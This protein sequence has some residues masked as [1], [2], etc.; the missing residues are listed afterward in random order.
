MEF[1]EVERERLAK[2]ERLRASGVEPYP[3]RS[4]F[5]RRR[6]MAAD[7]V[8]RALASAQNHADALENNEAA[9][10]GR[11]VARRIMGKAAF[12][13]VED[14]SGKIQ[15]YARVGDDSLDADSF[16]RFKELDLGD[17]IE[18]QGTLFVTKTGEPS[19]RVTDWRLLAKAISPLPIAKEEKAARW[20]GRALQRVQRS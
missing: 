11:I 13:G 5:A 12:L 9:V 18:A 20:I 1:T 7:A 8:R 17:F 14:V 16:A 6:V 15:F 2:L 10:M 19:L 4:Q 3:L